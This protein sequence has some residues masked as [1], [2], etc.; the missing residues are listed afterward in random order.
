MSKEPVKCDR[1]NC[2]NNT[3]GLC[4]IVA[5]RLIYR[6]GVDAYVNC[7]DQRNEGV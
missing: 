5:P 4:S 3:L 6:E 7:I 2:Q 1:L